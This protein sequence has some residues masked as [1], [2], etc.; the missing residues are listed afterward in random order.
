METEKTKVNLET[1]RARLLDEKNSLVVKREEFRTEIAALNAAGP[2][3]VLIRG[4]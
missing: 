3:N 2:S 4:H 1:D